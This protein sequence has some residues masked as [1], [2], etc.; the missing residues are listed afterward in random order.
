MDA[1][2]VSVSSGICNK[3]LEPVHA[4]KG[5]FFFGFFQFAMPLVGWY[6][7]IR[8]I[9]TIKD[10]DHWIAFGLLSLI[11]IKMILESVKDQKKECLDPDEVPDIQTDIRDLKTL[12]LLSF[13][14][15]IDALA[16]GITFSVIGEAIWTPAL[17]IGVVTFVIC[18]AGFEFGKRIGHIVEKRAEI[19]GG[20]VLIFI[21]TKILLE[22]LYF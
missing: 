18:L 2:A 4:L 21:G 16:V 9:D 19:L 14:T 11:G 5:A 22:H 10:F 8:F 15:S 3:K 13:A 17:L 1:F 20:F 6:L 7:G 12:L